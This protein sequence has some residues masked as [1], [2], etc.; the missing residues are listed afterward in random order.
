MRASCAGN[1]FAAAAVAFIISFGILYQ[2]RLARTVSLSY[3]T[4]ILYHSPIL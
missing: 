2:F 4:Y 1:V 3:I